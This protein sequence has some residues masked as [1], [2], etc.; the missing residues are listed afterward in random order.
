MAQF[1]KKAI[2]EAF[3]ELLGERPLDKITVKISLHAVALTVIR[4]IT[5]IRIFMLWL[6][7][8]SNWKHSVFSAIIWNMIPGRMLFSEPLILH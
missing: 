3:I 6:Q 2:I 5:I 1:T 7:I 4:F 8:F